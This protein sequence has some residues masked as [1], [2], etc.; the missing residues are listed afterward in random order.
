MYR[1]SILELRIADISYSGFP[2]IMIMGSGAEFRPG[3]EF[4]VVGLIMEM[5]KMG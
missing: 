4:G 5:W 2:S 1:L 3:K